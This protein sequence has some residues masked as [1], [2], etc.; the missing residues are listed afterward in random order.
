M[1]STSPD[2][3]EIRGWSVYAGV[4]GNK[5][6]QLFHFY[7]QYDNLNATFAY[8]LLVQPVEGTDKIKCTFSAFTDPKD[9]HFRNKD[10]LPIALPADLTPLVVRSGKV[11]SITTLPLGQAKIAAVHYLRLART[12]LTS[13]ANPVSDNSQT[14]ED[15]LRLAQESFTN[16]SG[17]EFDGSGLLQLDASP[18]RVKFP[19]VIAAAPAPLETP[20]APVF[21]A[22]RVGGPFQYTKAGEGSDEKPM[23]I[24]IP[25][26][27][28]GG[29]ERM[30]TNVTSVKEVETERLPLN[31]ATT[32]C[33]VLE[34][35]YAALPN[36]TDL[37][38]VRYS[39]CS[40]RHLALKKTMVYSAGRLPT[41][42]VGEW[43]ISFDTVHFHRPAPQ[44]L[45]DMKTLPKTRTHKE[46]LGK[47]AP[48]F[49]LRDL[50]GKTVELS[51]LRGKAVL[52][53]FWSTA[54]GPCI[55]EMPDI[56]QIASKHKDDLTVWGVSFDQPERTKKWLAQ[57]QQEFPTL[58][59]TEFEVSDLYNAALIGGVDRDFCRRKGEDNRS[60][61]QL[62]V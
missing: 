4:D 42:P 46:W 6:A 60:I 62:W 47:E 51:A 18:W 23:H 33:S 20:H 35:Q 24:A 56:Q 7:I 27:V 2:F 57:H 43:T 19:V 36:G 1:P 40:D 39:I 16:P 12:D 21:P 11:I 38:P 37:A 28:A 8:N 22:G 9:E 61:G 25:F 15:L 48:F 41:D 45:V 17:F 26:A 31:G 49:H 54:C 50:N 29:W 14:P 53:D 55:R 58:F 13:P 44:W 34:V 52:L 32:D 30:A 10:I 5:P 59:D 3:D